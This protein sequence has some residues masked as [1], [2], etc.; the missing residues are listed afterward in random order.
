MPESIESSLERSAKKTRREKKANDAAGPPIK[1][2][3]S[4]GKNKSDVNEWWHD[5]GFSNY[6]LTRPTDA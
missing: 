4:R 3:L 6:E 1:Q 5:E 2:R